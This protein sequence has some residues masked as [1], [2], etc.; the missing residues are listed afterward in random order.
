MSDYV[1]V[2][3]NADMKR[4]SGIG[5]GILKELSKGATHKSP[6]TTNM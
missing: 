2:T 6:G 5:T 3:H 1:S 4:L